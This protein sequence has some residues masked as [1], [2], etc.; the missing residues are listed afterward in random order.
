MPDR[1]P[2][3][4]TWFVGECL[5]TFL[6]VFFGCG[7]VCA[8]VLTG[9]QSGIFQV[10]VV[11][12]LGIG[13]AICV[14]GSLSG[15][16][17]NPAVSLSMATARR[18]PWSNVPGYVLA[19]FIGAFAASATLHAVFSGAFI[20]FESEHHLLR[21]APGS[22]SSAMALTE[23]Y[24]SPAWHALAGGAGV[25]SQSTACAV[26][27][28]GTAVLALVILSATDRRNASRPGLLAPS[29]IGLTVTLLISLFGPLTMAGFNPARDLAPR[30]YC[31]FAGWGSWVFRANGYGWLV[32][33]VLA[34]IAGGQA[35]ALFFTKV[36]GP[37]Y[38]AD[39]SSGTAL[40]L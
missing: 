27:A 34:P 17:L 20:Q 2:H 5:G 7:S 22:E 18:L 10:A 1:R 16:H 19:Q 12:G 30:L 25:V 35:A 11:W 21:G 9:A 26:E 15:A 28:L 40:R 33:Y 39:E 13:T 4:P 14:T 3:V 24:P 8:S 29:V 38:A 32:V 36:L 23:F 37:R 31:A 6:L